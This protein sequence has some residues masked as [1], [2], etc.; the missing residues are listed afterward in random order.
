[1]HEKKLLILIMFLIA[2][3]IYQQVVYADWPLPDYN[4]RINITI[5]Y[6]SPTRWVQNNTFYINISYQTGM[7]T[8]FKDLLFLNASGYNLSSNGFVYSERNSSSS[9]ATYYIKIPNMTNATYGNYTVSIYYNKPSA[10]NSGLHNNIT[11]TNA[12]LIG[13]TWDNSDNSSWIFINIPDYC[14]LTQVIGDSRFLEP[15]DMPNNLEGVHSDIDEVNACIAK[16]NLNVQ[17]ENFWINESLALYTW[18]NQPSTALNLQNILNISN[19][20][21]SYNLIYYLTQGNTYSDSGSNL[22]IPIKTVYEDNVNHTWYNISRNVTADLISKGVQV[23]Q[24]LTIYNFSIK[25]WA[26]APGVGKETQNDWIRFFAQPKNNNYTFSSPETQSSGTPTNISLWLNNSENNITLTYGQA[27]N[28]TAK[29]NVTGLWVAILKNG[30]LI[31]NGTNTATNITIWEAG[32]FNITAYYPGNTTYAASSRTYFANITKASTTINLSINGTQDNVTGT[33]PYPTNTTGWKTVSNGNLSLY[34]NG[35]IVNTSLSLDSISEI[36]QLPAGVYNYTLDLNHQNYSASPVTRFLTINKGDSGLNLV[37]SPSWSL[38][39]GQTVNISCSASVETPV[40][41]KDGIN[42]SNPYVATA[43]TGTYNFTCYISNT[44]YTPTVATNFLSVLPAGIGCVDNQTYAYKT[45]VGVSASQVVLNFTDLVNAFI[46]RKDLNDVLLNTSNASINKNLTGGYYILV[47]STNVSSFDL[48]FGSYPINNSIVLA[49]RSNETVTAFT[50]SQSSPY[51]NTFS[52]VEEMTGNL[53]NPPF[54]NR[55]S[56]TIFCGNGASTF[57]VTND[58]TQFTVASN[59]L[60]NQSEYLVMYSTTEIYLRNLLHSNPI[61]N[62][63]MYVVDATKDQVVQILLQLQDNTGL[64]NNANVH[65]RKLLGGQLVTITERPF[66][67][68]KKAIVYLINGQQYQITVDTPDGINSRTIGNIYIDTVNLIKTLVIGD[69]V[70]TN[71]SFGNTTYSLTYNTTTG[72]ISFNWFDP[73]YQTNSTEMWVYNYT[74]QS[75]LFFYANSTNASNV[76]FTYTV[77]NAND[78]YLVKIK[79][80]HALFGQNSIDINQIFTGIAGLPSVLLPTLDPLLITLG[81]GMFLIMLPMMFGPV[82]G[83]TAAI[84]T[85]LFALLLAYF[86]WFQVS[87]VIIVVVLLFA[88]FS[89][90]TERK[91]EG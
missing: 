89:K 75:Q 36:I 46:V 15:T 9:W 63:N 47:N 44:N 43:V 32:Y 14:S 54:T 48:F 88:I 50:Y 22:Y 77:P 59:S 4:S 85:A 53:M 26:N 56:M 78:T 39:S 61:D 69:L 58:T 20:T 21:N 17:A 76:S 45:T 71:V 2:F 68:E 40:L 27:L 64:F 10:D 42:V 65:I 62:R 7:N 86:K 38:T 23:T 5:A 84:L 49:N 12:L 72:V 73:T 3:G 24:N 37:A 1:M 25:T 51:I 60:V 90:I 57:N 16:K 28:S 13:T 82:H 6:F 79:I 31:A 34:R 70:T 35:T 74:N 33:Y 66:D 55:T 83:G 18:N 87:I 52:L 41:Q 29:I 19:G 8:T 80:R 67:A 81:S 30:T 11:N 91:G